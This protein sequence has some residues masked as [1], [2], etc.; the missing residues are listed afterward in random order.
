VPDTPRETLEQKNTDAL[1]ASHERCVAASISM[2]RSDAH[3]DESRKA[4]T[5]S[6]GLLLRVEERLG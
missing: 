2:A 4:I 3:V 5:R 6:R 1:A